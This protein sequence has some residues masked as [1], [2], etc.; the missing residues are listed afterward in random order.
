MQL[1]IVI[2]IVG[3]CAALTLRGVA[4]SL[5]GGAKKTGCGCSECPAVKPASDRR[6]AA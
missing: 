1:A 3:I 6:P 5:R 4:R 2:A